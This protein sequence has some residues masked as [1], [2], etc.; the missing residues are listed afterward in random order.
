MT[1]ADLGWLQFKAQAGIKSWGKIN[2]LV[3]LEDFQGWKKG[4]G[5]DYMSFANEHD[6]SIDRIAIV[7]PEQWRDLVSIFAGKGLRSTSVEYFLS[8]QLEEAKKWL[9]EAPSVS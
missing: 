3:V 4:P 8:S 1:S 7:G 2:A 9:D 6:Q 5:W